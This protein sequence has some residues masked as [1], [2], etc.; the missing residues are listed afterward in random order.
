MDWPPEN[1]KPT[2]DFTVSCAFLDCF[3]DGGAS[4]D[5]DGNIASYNWNF[6]DGSTGSG[7]RAYRVYTGPG[8]YTVQLTVADNEG[9]TASKSQTIAV[10]EEPLPGFNLTATGR[11]ARGGLQKV[12]LGWTGAESD[13]V[14]VYRNG[15]WIVTTLNA[16]FFTDNIDLRG[17]GTYTYQ[18]CEE[19][20]STC[21]N[22]T[23]VVFD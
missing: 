4:H 19:R 13:N 9:A 20:T 21:S 16:G 2:A 15:A 18:V 17:H 22:E 12:D 6:G 11:K 10:V 7:E 23:T 5:A 8:S 1:Q 14:D 3:F